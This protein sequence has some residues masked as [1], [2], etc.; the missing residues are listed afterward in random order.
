MKRHATKA[1]RKPAVAQPKPRPDALVDPQLLQDLIAVF[2][3]AGV[4]DL[5]VEGDGLRIRLRREGTGVPSS[6]VEVS[7]PV[8][9]AGLA[10]APTDA[11]T[12]EPAPDGLVTVRARIVGPLY[13]SA[14][15]Y[16]DV[17]DEE[18]PHVQRG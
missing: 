3:N 8:R 1:V 4:G 2:Q 17:S 14:S 6:P 5:E 9:A 18:G 12:A 11:R 7:V 15:P 16:A 13:R 10:V